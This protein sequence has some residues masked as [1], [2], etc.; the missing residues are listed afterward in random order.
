MT[1]SNTDRFN[2]NLTLSRNWDYL[3][4]RYVGTGS[5]DTS[6]EEWIQNIQRDTLA[7]GIG[8]YDQLM[9]FS[10]ATNQSIERTRLEMLNKMVKPIPKQSNSAKD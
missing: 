2:V 7:N 1:E 9:F 8:H 10:L 5:P 3:K 6:R 4:S